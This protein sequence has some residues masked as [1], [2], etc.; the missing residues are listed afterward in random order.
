MCFNVCVYSASQCREEEGK[1]NTGTGLTF[2][3]PLGKNQWRLPVT[4]MP[5]RQGKAERKHRPDV[6][7]IA[8]CRTNI[9]NCNKSVCALKSLCVCV[10]VLA[11]VNISL[12]KIMRQNTKVA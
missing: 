11:R 4:E 5:K 1:E 9:C 3:M 7:A 6:S 2:R 10:C 12:F 8:K